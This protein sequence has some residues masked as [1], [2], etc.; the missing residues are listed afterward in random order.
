MEGEHLYHWLGRF[1]KESPKTT[2]EKN[3]IQN[4]LKE[5]YIELLNND[6]TVEPP[7]P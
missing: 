4:A 3:E 5:Q 7:I 6:F 2:W 1:F